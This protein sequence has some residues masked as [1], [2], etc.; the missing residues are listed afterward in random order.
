MTAAA[1]TLSSKTTNKT[2]T[3]A[4]PPAPYQALAKMVTF[5]NFEMMMLM[6]GIL[7]LV[8]VA[9]VIGGGQ[10]PSP[11]TFTKETCNFTSSIAASVPLNEL[12]NQ[13]FD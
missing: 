4:S 8:L 9:A 10:R 7:L 13:A 11:A 2:I 12:S 3:L 6:T 1:E 5:E